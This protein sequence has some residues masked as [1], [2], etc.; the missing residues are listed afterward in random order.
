MQT[1]S[2]LEKNS[3]GDENVK[4]FVVHVTSLS[5]NSMP[6]YPAQEAQIALLVIEEVQIPELD[7]HVEA[8]VVHVTF[9]LTMPIYPA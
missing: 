3:P 4:A 7:K 2:L 8:F 1:F 9:L 5:L 6:I